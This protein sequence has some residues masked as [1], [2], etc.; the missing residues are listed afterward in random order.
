MSRGSGVSMT[1]KVTVNWKHGL[2][3]VC[4]VAGPWGACSLQH[5]PCDLG[6]GRHHPIQW[7]GTQDAGHSLLRSHCGQWGTH[8][9][10][11]ATDRPLPGY[12]HGVS[13]VTP[14][15]AC[16]ASGE[17]LLLLPWAAHNTAHHCL[18]GGRTTTGGARERGAAPGDPTASPERVSGA[19]NQACKKLL[20]PRH[21]P[22]TTTPQGWAQVRAAW[23]QKRLPPLSFPQPKKNE[24]QKYKISVLQPLSTPARCRSRGARCC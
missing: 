20:P 15:T 9:G 23:G 7:R 4:T 6:N 2:S 10:R 3:G 16:S 1:T 12:T 22:A 11:L 5:S 8:Q 13:S 14:G 17:H 24:A 18:T 19:E 21:A